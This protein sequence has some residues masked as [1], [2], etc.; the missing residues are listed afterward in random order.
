MF[1]SPSKKTPQSDDYKYCN[2]SGHTKKIRDIICYSDDCPSKGFICTMCL[3]TLHHDHF[4]QCIDVDILKANNLL[5]TAEMNSKANII[6]DEAIS[7]IKAYLKSVKEE[8]SEILVRLERKTIE[9][10]NDI[11]LTYHKSSDYNNENMIKSTRSHLVSISSKSDRKE[12][13]TYEITSQDNIETTVE[14]VQDHEV[15]YMPTKIP[16]KPEVKLFE[17]NVEV[18]LKNKELEENINLYLQA[19]KEKEEEISILE[20]E[21]EILIQNSLEVSAKMQNLEKIIEENEISAKEF[22]ASKQS[23]LDKIANEKLKCMVDNENLRKEVDTKD[24]QITELTTQH[25]ELASE[26][27]KMTQDLSDELEKKHEEIN[28]KS[29]E[30]IKMN[31]TIENMKKDFEKLNGEIVIIKGSNDYLRKKLEHR[32]ISIDDVI[33]TSYFSNKSKDTNLY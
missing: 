20:K 13:I 15:S 1:T 9:S 14:R 32:E 11:G 29:K 16:A 2:I 5:A 27:E 28:L 26:V 8:V 18:D 25:E 19:L 21:N 17:P 33:G 6:V 10:L 30:I 31:E 24:K 7:K 22:E 4:D 12:D 23:I 3:F